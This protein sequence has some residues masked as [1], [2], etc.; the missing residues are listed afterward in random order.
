MCSI[1]FE[2]LP[3]DQDEAGFSLNWPSSNS[4][5]SPLSDPGSFRDHSKYLLFH[6]CSPGRSEAA[7]TSKQV[8]KGSRTSVYPLAQFT[9]LVQSGNPS[10][11]SSE[12]AT[13]KSLLEYLGSQQITSSWLFTAGY[14]NIH[15]ELSSL[16]IESALNH[17]YPTKAAKNTIVT[18]SPWANGFYGSAGISGMLP[19]AYTQLSRKFLDAVHVRGGDD[20]VQL[21]EWR[22][23]TVGEPGGWTYHAKGI[24]ATFAAPPETSVRREWDVGPSITVVGSS[25]YTKRSYSLDLEVGALL[26]T[27]DDR[28]RRKLKEEMDWLQRDTKVVEREDLMKVERRVSWKVR[29]AMWIVEK[30]GGAL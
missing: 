2:V 5:P 8:S 19:D 30:V 28:L 1:S 24:W 4:C 21:K 12:Y 15:L 11:L 10:E 14:F 18:A 23:G 17:S 16:L 3:D 20:S 22:K 9:P 29:L 7:A 27:D 6:A 26:W 25:N 13:V